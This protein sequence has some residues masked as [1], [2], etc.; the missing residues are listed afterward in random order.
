MSNAVVTFLD[1]RL[2]VGAAP[3][4]VGDVLVLILLLSAGTI[5]HRGVE[6]LA[7]NPG[8]LTGTLAPFLV[9]WLV[10]SI[11]LGAYSP[12]AA[13]TQ[14][15][16]IP[17]AVRSWLVADAIGLGLRAT[18]LFHGEVELVFVVVTLV[19]GLVGLSAW[20]YLFFRLR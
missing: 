1:R 18:P 13:E 15:A 14:K 7:V 5:H 3:L 17:L 12:G 10:A 2:D 11:P 19:V 4:A 9:G 16:A 8:Y 6:F 20:R